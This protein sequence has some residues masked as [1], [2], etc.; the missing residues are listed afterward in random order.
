MK[1]CVCFSLPC[2]NF[3]TVFHRNEKMNKYIATKE[4]KFAKGIF[5]W[6]IKKDGWG[7]DF[8]NPDKH[9]RGYISDGEH[10][11]G[12]YQHRKYY[13]VSQQAKDQYGIDHI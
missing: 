11:F 13:S 1:L 8:V 9:P 4:C 10:Y 3:F 5:L 2:F 12:P 6:W 7:I